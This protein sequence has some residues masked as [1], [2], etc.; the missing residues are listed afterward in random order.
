[1]ADSMDKYVYCYA[2]GNDMSLFQLCRCSNLSKTASTNNLLLV[3]II[4]FAVALAYN[5]QLVAEVPT[6][7]KDMSIDAIVTECEFVLCSERA[8]ENAADME[9]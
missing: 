9:L 5:E 4:P 2:L 6:D 1:M 8:R 3:I 7:D